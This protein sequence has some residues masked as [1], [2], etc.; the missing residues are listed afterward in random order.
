MN[1][2]AAL[3][4]EASAAIALAIQNLKEANQLEESYDWTPEQISSFGSYL[5]Q[6]H[7]VSDTASKL[8]SRAGREILKDYDPE[9]YD[10]YIDEIQDRL[11]IRHPE[12]EYDSPALQTHRSTQKKFLP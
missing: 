9:N 12:Q 10:D 1:K 11:G 7:G 2:K 6:G 5:Y 4:E 3:L 8:R